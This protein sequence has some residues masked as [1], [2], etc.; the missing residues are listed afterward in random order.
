MGGAN[1]PVSAQASVA[2][3]AGDQALGASKR[4]F[5]DYRRD[6][7]LGETAPAASARIKVASSTWRALRAN[8]FAQALLVGSR[9]L[10][11]D[12]VAEIGNSAC[13]ACWCR[14]SGVGQ[15]WITELMRW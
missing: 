12:D 6:H 15:D 3:I 10:Y 9:Q 5:W 7:C 4:R 14:K 1:A 13:S 11:L 8:R 2:G